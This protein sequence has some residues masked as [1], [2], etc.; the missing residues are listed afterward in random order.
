[1][2]PEETIP[3]VMLQTC[4]KPIMHINYVPGSF[5]ITKCHIAHGVE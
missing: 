1:M 4:T 5:I 2:A 3:F